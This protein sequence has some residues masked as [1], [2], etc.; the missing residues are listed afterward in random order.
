MIR[1][2]AR[3]A[4]RAARALGLA[5]VTLPALAFGQE[6]GEPPSARDPLVQAWRQTR[7]RLEA[8]G[9]RFEAF[10][11]LDL[12][13]TV[14]GGKRRATGVLGDVDLVLTTELEELVGW[15]G[16]RAM[17]YVLGT[18]GDRPSRDDV[19]DLQG[20]SNIE[21]V[22]TWKL[23][24][25][26]I[27]Q[28][29]GTRR[30]SLL[31]G[32]YDVSSEFDVLP[33][34]SLFVHS[35]PG[36]GADLGLSGRNGPSAFPVTSI[37]ARLALEPADWSYARIVVA[38]GVPGDP[39]D[40]RGTEV[41]FDDGDGVLVVAELGL[42]DVAEQ[43][44]R[45]TGGRRRKEENGGEATPAHH[46]RHGKLAAGLWVY[47]SEFD[48]FVRTDAG[49]EPRTRDGS[50]GAYLLAEA[51]VFHEREDPDQGLSMFGRAGVADPRTA[52]VDAYLGGGAVYRGALPGRDEDELGLAVAA[53]HLGSDYRKASSRAGTT[54]ESWEVA[55]EL[56]YRFHATPW[57]SIQPDM[58]VV[59]DPGGNAD[60]DDA[61][62]VGARFLISL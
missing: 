19:G 3:R 4:R 35:S 15:P 53:A 41:H 11:T 50:H 26:W 25:A 21:D 10:Y 16:A 13:S 47:T 22:D 40:P 14:A 62:V 36:T 17:F 48:D 5:I 7:S 38:D 30:A 44:E 33:T 24:E 23:Y 49:G 45:V 18:H 57:L 32:L 61:V 46:A 59:F 52:V 58:Q 8:R 37:A 55:L 27:E 6:A 60:L 43:K 54:L 51:H 56:S 42:V 29:L 20:V 2:P 28:D 34:A 31:A 9:I 12:L 1:T 39:D